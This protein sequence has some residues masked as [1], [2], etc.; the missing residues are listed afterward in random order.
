MPGKYF[1]KGP[2]PML[3]AQ[4]TADTVN[5]PGCSVRLYHADPAWAR[6]Y[7]DLF[8]ASHTGPYWGTNAYERLVVRVTL[9]FFNRYVLGQ[10]TAGPAMVRAGNVKGLAVLYS[11][12]AGRLANTPCND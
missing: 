9:A 7:L 8:G 12:G 5:Y 3:F 2:V 11:H 4:G 1:A 10:A 6:Y